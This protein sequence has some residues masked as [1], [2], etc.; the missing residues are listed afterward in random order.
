MVEIE[1][2]E[3][4]EKAI[5]E[6]VAVLAYFSSNDC[7]V[8]HVLRPKIVELIQNAFPNIQLLHIN[9][10]KVPNIHGQYRIFTA[11]TIIV[12]FEG[13]MAFTKS[14]N[15]SIPT[16]EKEIERPYKLRFDS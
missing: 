7:G 9:M 4:F 1:S 13:N 3:E 11:P 6:N 8:C 15:I 10:N 12:F 2:L 5:R 16:L 14:R